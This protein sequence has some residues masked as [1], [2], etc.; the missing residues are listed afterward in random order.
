MVVAFTPI[1]MIG[2]AIIFIEV[3][4][5]TRSSSDYVRSFGTAVEGDGSLDAWEAIYTT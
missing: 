2:I 4:P 1:G 5:W 3:L